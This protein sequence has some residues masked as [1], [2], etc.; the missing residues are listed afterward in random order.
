MGLTTALNFALSGLSLN[1]RQIS[2]TSGNLANAAN[3][4]YAKREVDVSARYL[5]PYGSGVQIDQI[6]R[7]VDKGLSGDRMLAEAGLGQDQTMAYY[8]GRV[9]DIIGLPGTL[10]SLADRLAAVEEALVAASGD[11]GSDQRLLSAVNRM[12]DLTDAMN[13]ASANLQIERQSADA[14]I[15]RGV[16]TINSALEQIHSLNADIRRAVSSG[17][18]AGGL[19]DERQA[20]IDQISEW[21]PVRTIE[22]PNRALALMTVSGEVMMDGPPRTYEFTQHPTIT[23]DMTFAGGG[24]S[25]VT[26]DG[27]GMGTVPPAV[28][29][30][31]GGKLGALF[32]VR[33]GTMVDAQ[34]G[35]D[36]LAADLIARFEDATADPTRGTSPGLLTDAG[37]V[38]D[39][40]D[41][42]GLSRRISV[43][44]SVDPASGGDLFRLRDGVGAVTAGPIGSDVQLV[45]WINALESPRALAGGG[46]TLSATEHMGAYLQ[47]R[48]DDRLTADQQESYAAARYDTLR[49]AELSLG[50]DTDAELQNLLRIEQAYAA[51]VRIIQAVDEMMRNLREI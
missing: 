6:R 46:A 48:A 38:L 22:R 26:R 39:P 16:A 49:E 41:T 13:T 5:G 21:V 40:L 10:G 17:L 23:A 24:L 14:E 9:E 4:D 28:G 18:D 47:A 45:N 8:A 34:S 2:V 11:P 3:E 31:G 19:E 27:A 1:S 51:N 44:T 15:A 12:T 36:A 20:A 42:V 30:L 7:V 50:V 37:A 29:K 43:N 25:G 35:L 32:D 33:D